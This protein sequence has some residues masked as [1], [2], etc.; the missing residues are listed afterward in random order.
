MKIDEFEKFLHD[1]IPITEAM[2]IEAEEFGPSKV[3]LSA[4]LEPNVN[5]KGTAFGG[6][7]S[8]LMTLCGWSMMFSLMENHDPQAKIVVSKSS[9]RYIAPAKGDLAAEC[10]LPVD[11]SA[12]EFLKTYREKGKARLSLK[13]RCFSEGELAADYEGQY[14]AYRSGL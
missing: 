10:K 3:R 2:K 6:S 12:E 5:D 13:V 9:M 8:S 7:I 4:S 11:G 1:K 14:V